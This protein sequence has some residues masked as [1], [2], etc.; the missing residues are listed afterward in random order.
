MKLN[1][2]HHVLIVYRKMKRNERQ[3]RHRK[4]RQKKRKEDGK[5]MEGKWGQEK[6]KENRGPPLVVIDTK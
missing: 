6:G 2:R 3:T 4:G 5:G 1:D